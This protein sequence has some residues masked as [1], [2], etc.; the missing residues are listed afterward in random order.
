E[1]RANPRFAP[2]CAAPPVK[3]TSIPVNA[4]Q[5]RSDRVSAGLELLAVDNRVE[6]SYCHRS[7]THEL[8]FELCSHVPGHRIDQSHAFG[9]AILQDRASRFSLLPIANGNDV[10]V[11]ETSSARCPMATV[12]RVFSHRLG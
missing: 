5:L 6:E 3:L 9:S 2:T 10:E 4:H 8:T 12:G 7:G 11:A 1:S